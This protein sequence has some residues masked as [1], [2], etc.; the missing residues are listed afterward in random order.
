MSAALAEL[1]AASQQQCTAL[2]ERL[3]DEM[4]TVPLDRGD[5]D[6]GRGEGE[7]AGAPSAGAKLVQAGESAVAAYRGEARGPAVERVLARQLERVCWAVAARQLSRAQRTH[8]SERAVLRA[9][10][11]TAEARLEAQAGVLRGK[12]ELLAAAQAAQV[13]QY[14]SQLVHPSFAP[15]N[16]LLSVESPQRTQ[17]GLTEE[18]RQ[19]R[20]CVHSIRALSL[21]LSL[22]LSLAL[23]R[24]VSSLLSRS[25]K[26][27]A[28]D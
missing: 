14:P 22:S 13:L 15:P 16:A 3:F 8:E 17:A 11:A 1:E 5:F 6:G 12:E 19:A 10:A 26:P 2:A 21:S 28:T 7:G 25:L 23:S 9:E 20:E 18:L 24:L 4:L 27:P